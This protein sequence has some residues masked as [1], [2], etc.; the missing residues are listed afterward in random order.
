MHD[1]PKRT[2]VKKRWSK[3]K[4][5][6]QY[7]DIYLLF[8]L[9]AQERLL[10][11]SMDRSLQL[12]YKEINSGCAI[13]IMYLLESCSYFIDVHNHLLIKIAFSFFDFD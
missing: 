11:I 5:R 7:T 13:G 1:P 8:D 10:N 9:S 6:R 2:L 3:T 12:K 4:R